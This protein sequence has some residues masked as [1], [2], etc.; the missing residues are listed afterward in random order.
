MTV[1]LIGSYLA[2]S[3]GAS[4]WSR[5]LD[6]SESS[7]RCLDGL[8]LAVDGGEDFVAGG[9]AEFTLKNNDHNISGHYIFLT[10]SHQLIKMGNTCSLTMNFTQTIRWLWH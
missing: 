3:T 8:L 1:W 6:S 5:H 4:S 10:A 9:F 2:I 7:K